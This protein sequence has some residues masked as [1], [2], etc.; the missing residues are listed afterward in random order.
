MKRLIIKL[1]MLSASVNLYAYDFE[2]DGIYYNIISSTEK[3][4]EVTYEN[5]GESNYSDC[6][7]N[8]VIPDQVTYNSNTYSVIAIGDEAFEDCD[9]MT[10]VTIPSSVTTIGSSA[11]WDCI[12]LKTVN[13]SDLSAWCK[14]DFASSSSNPLC[15]AHNLYL[16]G[17]LLTDLHRTDFCHD[18]QQRHINRQLR[19]LRL[20]RADFPHN[21]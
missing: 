7:G 18:S 6:F 12:R 21:W 8:V 3:T 20:H 11:F 4:V 15:E 14:I 16:N 13:I 10:S 17:K 1:L 5:G 2:V 19:F 9:E